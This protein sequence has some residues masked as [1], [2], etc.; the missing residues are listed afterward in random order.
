MSGIMTSVISEI[1]DAHV[2]THEDVQRFA[3][4]FGG[5]N[6]V[7]VLPQRHLQKVANRQLV[8]DDEQCFRARASGWRRAHW[9][10]T[11]EANTTLTQATRETARRQVM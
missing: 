1:D 3:S 7:A 9:I 2:A 5:Q 8:L 6:R 4:G 10:Q 11:Y